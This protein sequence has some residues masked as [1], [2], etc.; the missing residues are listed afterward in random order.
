LASAS[1]TSPHCCNSACCK[2][3]GSENCGCAETESGSVE[4][5]AL[6]PAV[7]T[8]GGYRLAAVLLTLGGDHRC[9][10]RYASRGGGRSGGRTVCLWAA[11]R[12][13]APHW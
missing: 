7:L 5:P 4:L 10:C 6:V 2:A 3:E 13:W 9:R 8:F 1:V 11:H 12:R